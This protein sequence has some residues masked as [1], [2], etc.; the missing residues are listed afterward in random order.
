MWG[1]FLMGAGVLFLLDR[2]GR[3]DLRDIWEYWP[4]IFFFIGI[5]H[6]LFPSRR[7]AIRFAGGERRVCH[8]GRHDRI[9]GVIWMLIGV[10]FFAN[11]FGWWGF[12]YSRSWPVM[13]LLI[14][15]QT[16]FRALADSRA[17]RNKVEEVQS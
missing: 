10:W 1:V 8:D 5:S 12:R 4:A 3:L 17:T 11:Q 7:Q 16:V 13:V 2:M 6:L 14:G 15:L 9:D